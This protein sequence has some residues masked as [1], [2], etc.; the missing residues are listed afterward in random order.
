MDG[1]RRKFSREF[2]LAVLREIDAGKSLAQAAREHEVHPTQIGQWRKMRAQYA[3]RAFA[4]NGRIYKDEARMAE[5][6]RKI[7]QLTMEN[8]F[9]KK[10]LERLEELQD[11]ES[12]SPR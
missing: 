5:L 4:G 3:E 6:E 7:G 1:R 2:K 12:G 8:D 10:V 11:A 9:L